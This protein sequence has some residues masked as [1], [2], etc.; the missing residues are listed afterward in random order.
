MRLPE[1]APTVQPASRASAPSHSP[2]RA[3][4]V[5]L[6]VVGRVIGGLGAPG[7]GQAAGR[8]PRV[9]GPAS[10]SRQ[11]QAPPR[12]MALTAPLPL[13]PSHPSPSADPSLR[14]S[15]QPLSLALLVLAS[16]A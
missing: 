2:K 15:L 11:R 7:E 16:L 3:G 13:L 9:P 1:R 5:S 10:R 12:G 8:R 14:D 6:P 4:V